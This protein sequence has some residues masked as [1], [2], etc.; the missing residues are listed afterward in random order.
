M[1]SIRNHAEDTDE[2]EFMPIVTFIGPMVAIALTIFILGGA[3]LS[4]Q[5]P[6]ALAAS[7]SIIGP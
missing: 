2:Q 1:T 7:E 5:A 4:P 3:L 6:L